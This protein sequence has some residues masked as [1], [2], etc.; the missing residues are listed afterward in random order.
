MKSEGEVGL[1]EQI[2]KGDLLVD[3]L[4]VV[5][6]GVQADTGRPETG[7]NLEIPST[8]RVGSGCWDRKGKTDC[9][10]DSCLS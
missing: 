10:G 3:E 7:D 4:P 6:L 1:V 9:C 8:S 5:D 2:A